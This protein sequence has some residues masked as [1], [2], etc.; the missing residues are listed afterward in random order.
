MSVF[1]AA[2][3]LGVASGWSLSNLAMQKTLY[4]AQSTHAAQTGSPLFAE[5]FEAWDYGP[6]VP[7]LYHAA[8]SF[9]KSA[10]ADIFSA[11]PF[12]IG[13]TE[14]ASVCE[15]WEAT[16]GMTAGQLVTLTHRP[17][18][19]WDT[20]YE[21]NRRG[22]VIPFGLIL[23]EADPSARASEEAVAWASAVADQLEKAPSEY[24]DSQNER[25][26][27]A[28]LRSDHLGESLSCH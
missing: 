3:T 14:Y 11:A 25:A 26:F 2:R 23:R 18:G 19:A 12:A 13:S 20:C 9:R 10:V 6:V 8:K 24:L 16:R 15:A 17:G 27:R 4:V 7:A 5:N 28:R 22:A 21:E 1:R